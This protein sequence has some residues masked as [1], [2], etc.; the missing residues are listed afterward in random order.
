LNRLV[1]AAYL[2]VAEIQAM[3]RQPMTMREWVERLH[4][5]W[6]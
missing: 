5:F 2:K 6:P 3:S 1:T 4:Q